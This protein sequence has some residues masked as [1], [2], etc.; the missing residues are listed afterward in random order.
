MIRAYVTLQCYCNRIINIK[1]YYGFVKNLD[2]Y[3]HEP[4]QRYYRFWYVCAKSLLSNIKHIIILLISYHMQQ[5]ISN[6][7][8]QCLPY[9]S[10]HPLSIRS[11][12]IYIYQGKENATYTHIMIQSCTLYHPTPRTT[13]I[14]FILFIQ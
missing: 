13:H 14:Q 11:E 9:K 10:R 5:N 1:G 4:I 3:L 2:L 8:C 12:S 6:K 7:Q